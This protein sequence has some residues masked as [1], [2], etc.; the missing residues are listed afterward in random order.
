[1]KACWRVV[2]PRT[3]RISGLA[4]DEIGKRGQSLLFGVVL[5]VGV[6][7]GNL[8]A[9]MANDVL[10]DGRGDASVFHHAGGRGAQGMEGQL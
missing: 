6:V 5:D 1:M 10:H 3:A 2:A 7:R 8:G 9:F 4:L